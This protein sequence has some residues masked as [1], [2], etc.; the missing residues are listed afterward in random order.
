VEIKG[1]ATLENTVFREAQ[2]MGWLPLGI[3]VGVGVLVPLLLLVGSWF[4]ARRRQWI[5]MGVLVAVGLFMFLLCAW[6]YVSFD[7]MITDV[8]P[9]GIRV[10]FGWWPNHMRTIPAGQIQAAEVVHYDPMGEYG[11]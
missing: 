8:T 1:G 4:L 7:V 5:A 2:F 9:A 10:W 3:L 6:I 11:G